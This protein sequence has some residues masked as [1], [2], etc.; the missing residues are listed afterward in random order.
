MRSKLS[1]LTSLAAVF[2]LAPA[3]PAGAL[4]LGSTTFPAASLPGGC[5]NGVIGQSKSDP[6]TPYT[7]PRSGRITDWQINTLDGTSGSAVSLVVMETNGPGSYKVVGFDNEA[8]PSPLPS[9][10][11]ASFHVSSPIAVSSGDLLGLDAGEGVVCYFGAG[12][13][14]QTD[15]LFAAV[16]GE[17]L[18][19]GLPLTVSGHETGLTLNLSATEATEQDAGVSTTVGP[20]NA[21]VGAIAQL[22]ST[23]SN[24]GPGTGPITFSDNVAAG[25]TIDSAVA[26]SGTCAIS[27]QQVS[28]TI[29]GLASGQSAPVV[30]SV[31]PTA[32]GSLANS[33]SVATTA[34]ETDPN[35]ANN[36]ATATL[37]VG[38]APHCVVPTLAGTPLA[39]AKNVLTLLGCRVGKI[40][41][42]SS[43]KIGKGLV[44]ST[45]PG[46]ATLAAGA[47]VNLSVSS[48]PPKKHKRSKGRTP[49]RKK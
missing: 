34:G 39:V 38:I 36:A 25:L 44:I 47:T 7:V 23:V 1:L 45:S 46:A 24:A 17:A 20:A 32:A 40:K 37:I 8:L 16:P 31:T 3:A 13:I 27:A 11:V 22:S 48:G 30:I 33:V 10:G 14:P 15:E 9:N 4:T 43:R 35:S 6:S 42:A 18:K 29:N 12:G 26:G 2:V 21:S 49:A 28:C 19:A 41:K 5:N